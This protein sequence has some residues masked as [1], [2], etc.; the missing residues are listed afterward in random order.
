MVADPPVAAPERPRATERRERVSF[1]RLLWVAPLTVVAA[2]L[3]NLGIRAVAQAIDPSLV[4]L[5][6]LQTLYL[7]FTVLGAVAAVV[8]FTLLAVFTKKP[9]TIFRILAVPALLLSW[10]PDI[11]LAAGGQLGAF[12]MQVVGPLMNLL[13]PGPGGPPPGA[14]GPPPG[15]GGPPPGGMPGMPIGSVAVLMLMH[16][17]TFVVSTGLLTTLPRRRTTA[18]ADER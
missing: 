9:F 16:L 18:A 15:A 8:I 5:P 11:G 14:G 4:R 3:V 7:S 13:S 10:I 6:S 12:S 17:A 1:A 2:L